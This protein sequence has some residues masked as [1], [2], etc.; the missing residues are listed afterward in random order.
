[1]STDREWLFSQGI[2]NPELFGIGLRWVSGA[3]PDAETV[4][5][6]AEILGQQPRS[7]DDS[8]YQVEIVS[9]A[10]REDRRAVAYVRSRAKQLP[11]LVDVTFHLVL[12]ELEDKEVTWEIETYNP[13]FGC[14][15]RLLEWFDERVVIIIY[16]E[17]HHTY[18]CRF[19]F[20]EAVER[21][22]IE[23][24]WIRAGDVVGYRG[25]KEATVRRIHLPDISDLSPV[26]EEDARAQQLLPTR[27]R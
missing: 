10:V 19:G 26:A 16:R 27:R 9:G 13:F 12:R 7:V 15:V 4:R 2:P 22:R 25:L 24:D 5:E 17:K 23:D 1:M 11:D 20:D 8:G 21:R 3:G 18:V 6:V 14:D